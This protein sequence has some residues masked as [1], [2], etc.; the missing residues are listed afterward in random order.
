MAFFDLPVQEL[1]QYRGRAVEPPGLWDFWEQTLASSRAAAGSVVADP[2][3]T[4]LTLVDTWDVTFGGY[5]GH[6]IK[7]WFHRPANRAVDV[8]VVV[9]YQGYGS[10]RGLPHVVP[11]WALAGYAV[12][13][14]DTR[15]QGSAWRVGHTDDPHGSGPAHPGFLTRGL[16]DPHDHYYRRVL[17]DATLAVDAVPSLPGADPSRVAVAGT[18]QGGGL[19]IA[20]AALHDDVAAAM[21]DVPFL[22]DYRRAIEV[23]D[24]LPYEEL[25]TWLSIHRDPVAVDRA[26]VTLDHVDVAL[27]ATRATCPAL[28]SVALMDLTCPPSTVYAAH[29]AW[30]GP[31]EMMVYPYNDHEGGQEDHQAHQLAWLPRFLPS[32]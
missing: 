31:A 18:S 17:T 16:H 24:N 11:F 12:L 28:F 30:G 1:Q 14:V 13:D 2:V 26:L 23:T 25:Q 22:A 29:N 3:D 4:G 5:A 10:G 27:L 6:P 9:R 15:G 19:A 32:R 8:P 21:P 20:A 7:A